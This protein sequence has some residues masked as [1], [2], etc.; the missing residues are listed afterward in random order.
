MS[1]MPSLNGKAEKT[2]DGKRQRRRKSDS[3]LVRHETVLNISSGVGVLR[4]RLFFSLSLSLLP[5]PS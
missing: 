5:E 1:F 3:A 4:R 2:E